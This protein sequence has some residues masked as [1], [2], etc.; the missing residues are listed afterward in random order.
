MYIF[1]SNR[2]T[3]CPTTDCVLGT[4][5]T[6]LPGRSLADGDKYCWKTTI[7]TSSGSLVLKLFAGES[8]VLTVAISPAGS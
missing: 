1:S 2:E 8:A 3:S 6:L 4:S 5:I 7:T